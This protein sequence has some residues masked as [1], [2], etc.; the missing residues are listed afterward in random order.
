MNEKQMRNEFV[1]AVGRSRRSTAVAKI[2][3]KAAA[4]A[5]AMFDSENA[6]FR[7]L[8]CDER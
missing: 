5:F 2:I 7:S 4:N 8:F 3:L 6:I 1:D